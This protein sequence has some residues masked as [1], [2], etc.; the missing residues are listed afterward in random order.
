[1]SVELSLSKGLL[2]SELDLSSC[3][4]VTAAGLEPL[5]ELRNLVTLN[6]YRTHLANQGLCAIIRYNTNACKEVHWDVPVKNLEK[7]HPHD[8]V[9]VLFSFKE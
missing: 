3:L 2:L 7:M 5:A 8:C 1:M 4:N 6:V 9:Y